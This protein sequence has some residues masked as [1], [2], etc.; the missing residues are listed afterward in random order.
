MNENY[1]SKS[2]D[3]DENEDSYW[4][5]SI[6]SENEWNDYGDEDYYEEYGVERP[7]GKNARLRA[8]H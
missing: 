5:S 2:G 3:E 8:K 6:E 1:S 4:F 7:K